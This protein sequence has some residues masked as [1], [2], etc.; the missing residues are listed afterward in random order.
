MTEP[1]RFCKGCEKTKPETSE[2]FK[3][4][5]TSFTATCIACLARLKARREQKKAK[6]A[7]KEN[8]EDVPRPKEQ[9]GLGHDTDEREE[10]DDQAEFFTLSELSLDVFLDAITTAAEIH[11]FSAQVNVSTLV[12]DENRDRADLLA[13]AIWERLNYR[14]V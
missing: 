10:D 4:A 14:F 9:G 1:T 3:P 13:E 2:Y 12:G 11:T 6:D 8:I 7:Q 5:G